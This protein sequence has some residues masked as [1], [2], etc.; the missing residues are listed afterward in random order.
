MMAPSARPKRGAAGAAAGAG[1]KT[2]RDFRR[3]QIVEAARALVAAGGLEAL[4]IGALEARLG[5]TRGVITYHFRDKDEIVDALFDSAV[6]EIDASTR[7]E[8]EASLDFPAKVE[9]VLRTNVRGF[10]DHPEASYVLFSFWSRLRTD[11]RARERSAR[12]YETYRRRSARLIE[13][14][15]A[16]GVC[17]DAPVAEVAALLVGT[18]IGIVTQ[19]Y[20]A[21][22]AIDPDACVREAAR[23]FAAR[24]AAPPGR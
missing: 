24:L 9:A 16:A 20:F 21:P 7:A 11:R 14:G 10:L 22:S 6:A 8:V 17:R 19:V 18:V 1:P 23:T 2:V 15:R 12:L 3:A 13:W 4:T 5:F